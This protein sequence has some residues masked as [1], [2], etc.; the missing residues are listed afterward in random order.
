MKAMV[1]TQGEAEAAALVPA[2]AEVDQLVP[3]IHQSAQ[4]GLRRVVKAVLVK[5]NLKWM[6]FYLTDLPQ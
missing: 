6:T 4:H 1:D 2:Q 3:V 5:A